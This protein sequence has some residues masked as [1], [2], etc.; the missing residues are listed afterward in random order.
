MKQK[1]DVE[2]RLRRSE[3]AVANSIGEK[4][5]HF[6]ACYRQDRLLLFIVKENFSDDLRRQ[7]GVQDSKVKHLLKKMKRVM[8]Q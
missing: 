1:S 3:L 5:G 6:L 2:E 4:I 8:I 7:N